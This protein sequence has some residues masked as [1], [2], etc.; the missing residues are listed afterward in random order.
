MAVC[1]PLGFQPQWPL[2]PLLAARPISSPPA[3][4]GAGDP[5]FAGKTFQGASEGSQ[6]Y[7]R[8]N[9][10]IDLGTGRAG[11]TPY[12]LENEGAQPVGGDP[13]ER[14]PAVQA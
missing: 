9:S 5:F 2:V 13:A 4:A 8:T 14:G 10:S 1:T 3:V 6:G 11:V 12:I 7:L